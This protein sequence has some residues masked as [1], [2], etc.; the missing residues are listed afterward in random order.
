MAIQTIFQHEILT[1]FAYPFLLI[2]FIVFAVLEKTKLL[3]EDKKQLNALISFVI[4]LIFLSVLSEQRE[5][6]VGNLILFLT[7]AL[8]VMFVALLLWG[9][10]S[11]GDFK[12]DILSN[13]TVKWVVGIC[14]MV[15]VVV[16]LIWATGMDSGVIDLLFEQSWSDALWTNV[17]FGV[18]IA[19]A[20]ALVLKGKSD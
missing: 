16:A 11:G 1:K 15:A 14:V 8:V 20:L 19:I 18:V 12:D 4:G 17:A 5:M 13:K 2:F 10:V 9:F 7:I 3:G 6:I